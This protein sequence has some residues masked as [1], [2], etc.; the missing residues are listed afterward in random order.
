MQHMTLPKEIW[1]ELFYE[2]VSQ[3]PFFRYLSHH[4]WVYNFNFVFVFMQANVN[5]Y[6]CCC[7]QL[8]EEGMVK[9]NYFPT[10]GLMDLMYFPYYG[11]SL[12]VSIP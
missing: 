10:D 11:K 6:F 5:F 4:H 9:I 7:L 8:Q 1:F 2:F 12:H 3:L